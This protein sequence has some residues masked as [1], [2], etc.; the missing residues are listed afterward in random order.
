M[1]GTRLI[2]SPDPAIGWRISVYGQ[3]EKTSDGGVTWATQKL[4][5]D[6]SVAATAGAAP[7]AMSSTERQNA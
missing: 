2:A 5:A 6:G 4:P 7:S 1:V 3:V